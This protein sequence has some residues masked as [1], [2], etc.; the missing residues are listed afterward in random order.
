MKCRE[1]REIK[2]PQKTQLKNGRTAVKGTCL[3]LGTK[4]FPIG[5]P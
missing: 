3:E 4:V 5:K 2:D 1:K